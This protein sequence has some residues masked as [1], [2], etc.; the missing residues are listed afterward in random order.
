MPAAGW[1]FDENL[2]RCIDTVLLK[3]YVDLDSP[4]VDTFAA[5]VEHVDLVNCEPYLLA[6][7]RYN[8]LAWLCKNR[9]MDVRALSIWSRLGSGE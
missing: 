4:C 2:E 6:Q 5:G 1:V 9:G 8:A 3:L 7:Q